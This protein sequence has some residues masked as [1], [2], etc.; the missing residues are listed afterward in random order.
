MMETFEVEQDQDS[1]LRFTGEL[2]GSASSA[3][4]GKTRWAE[5]RIFRTEGGQYVVAGVGRTIVDG[6]LDRFWA[7]VCKT[8]DEVVDAIRVTR[9]DPNTHQ[10]QQRFIP[11]VHR[12]ALEEA[13]ERDD[14]LDDAYAL[15]V[16]LVD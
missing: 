12:R 14:A 3:R 8:P 5:L 9:R 4:E 6:E 11:H 7:R 1:L 13:I 2:L 15:T 16:H 10:V